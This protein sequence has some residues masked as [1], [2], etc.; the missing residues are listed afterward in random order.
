MTIVENPSPTGR[1]VSTLSHAIPQ[2]PQC[3]QPLPEDAKFC[4]ECGASLRGDRGDRKEAERELARLKKRVGELEYQV[5][6]ATSELPQAVT[7]APELELTLA[8][9]LR[10]I[11][12][13]LQAEKCVFMLHDPERGELQAC[14]PALGF[15]DDQLEML[16]V[17]ATRGI[18]GEA[19][20]ESKPVIVNDAVTDPRT[21]EEHVALLSIRNCLTVPLTMERKDDEE[22]MVDRVTIGVLHVFNK[23][24]GGNFVNEDTML[25]TVLARQAA[26]VIANAQILIKL[27]KEKQQLE[28]TLQSLVAGV[29]VVEADGHISLINSAACQIFEIESG[30]GKPVAE[31]ILDERLL[32][33]IES[34]VRDRI[35]AELEV[36]LKVA[37]MPRIY[38]AQ[39]ALVKGQGEEMRG[40]VAIF[41]DITE[42]RNVEKMKSAFVST[43]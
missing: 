30:A 11:A 20:R 6:Q 22:R 42:I 24:F 8:R 21:M 5:R 31:V 19:F 27:T 37:G 16:R 23:R 32:K 15:S 17:P 39:T 26:A 40:V 2:C 13:I 1:K 28:A 4:L 38:Q 7:T 10:K 14:K 33:L 35:E 3:Q 41:S 18:S 43:V 25:L 9:L 36:E 29:V 12:M 34:T